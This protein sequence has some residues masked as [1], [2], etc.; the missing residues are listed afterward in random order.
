MKRTRV[1]CAAF[2]LALCLVLPTNGQAASLTYLGGA[3]N[4]TGS[5][6]V[7][8]GT[9]ETSK[10]FGPESGLLIT[11]KA[12]VVGRDDETSNSTVASIAARCEAGVFESSLFAQLYLFGDGPYGFAIKGG[13]DLPPIHSFFASVS[14]AAYTG[15]E[16]FYRLMPEAGEHFGDLGTFNLSEVCSGSGGFDRPPQTA[17]VT[18]KCGPT[19][20]T[21]NGHTI[22]SMPE[23]QGRGVNRSTSEDFSIRIGDIIGLTMSGEVLASLDDTDRGLNLEMRDQLQIY[24][25]DS[26]IPAPAPLPSTG[27]LSGFGLGVLVF[28]RS[29]KLTNNN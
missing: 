27:L 22:Y 25:S 19:T 13:N 23:I 20:V 24:L 29:R 26:F 18:V 6:L 15:P 10:T 7:R 14:A 5:A 16:L 11:D 1:V 4:A 8:Y 17:D 12:E 9:G 28:Y 21:I 3:L 2:V